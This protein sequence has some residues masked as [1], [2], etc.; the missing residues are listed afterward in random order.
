MLDSSSEL[1]SLM[2]WKLDVT[3]RDTLTPSLRRMLELCQ[4]HA[5]HQRIEL[6]A[7]GVIDWFEDRPPDVAMDM[8]ISL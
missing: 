2:E 6:A 1:V 5:R 8:L 7:D 4:P 3:S